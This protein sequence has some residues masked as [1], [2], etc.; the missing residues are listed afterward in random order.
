MTARTEPTVVPHLRVIATFGLPA[1]SLHEVP[2]DWST[3]LADGL[4]RELLAEV[5]RR[6]LAGL[7]LG[8]VEAGA[9]HVTQTQYRELG[10]VHLRWSTAALDLEVALLE[11]VDVLRA[12]G[13]EVIVLKGA[14][15]AHV[16]YR[17][18]SWRLFGDNDLL[19]RGADVARAVRLLRAIGYVRTVPELRHGFDARFGKGVTLHRPGGRE[20]D[21]HRTLLF[22]TFGLR[23]DTDELFRTAGSMD[24]AG[25]RLDVLGA[26]SRLLHLCYHAALGDPVP[27]LASLRDLAQAHA[28]EGHDEWGAVDLARRWGALPVVQRAFGLLR[29][30]LGVSIVGPLADEAR[31]CVLTAED[32]RAIGSY[33]GPDR[34]HT[35]KVLASLP[36]LDGPVERLAF[37]R[38]AA[39]PRAAVGRALGAGRWTRLKRGAASVRRFPRAVVDLRPRRP[40]SPSAHRDS[41]RGGPVK[42]K[43]LWLTKGLGLGGAERLLTLTAARLD[44]SRFEVDVAYVLPW[45]DAFVPELEAAGVRT[46]CLGASRTADPGWALGLRRL[47][48]D[49][50]YDIVH[51]HSPVPAIVARLLVDRSTKLVHTEHNLWDRYRWPTFAANAVTYARN[52][53][54][55]AVSDGVADSVVRPWWA[56]VGGTPEVET[57]LHGV[58]PD[59]VPRGAKARGAA[60]DALGLVADTP[61]LG[62]VANLT[63]KKD[64]VSLLEALVEVRTAHPAVVLLLI[65]AGPS[66]AD[67]QAKVAALDLGGSVRFLGSRSDVLDLLPALDVFVLSSRYE[68]LPISL[69]E[70][71]AAEVACVVT[72]VGGIPEVISDGVDGRL[73]PP[74]DPAALSGA[75]T[76]VLSDAGKREALAQAGRQRV[77]A[78]F[79]IDRAVARTEQLYAQ[80]LHR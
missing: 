33:V 46:I 30:D 61:V 39:L 4:W 72:R 68:G 65:G 66:E 70:A 32:R 18:P 80:L 76:D 60:R 44:R 48:H 9:L 17:D 5:D 42:T 22:G 38:S 16:L 28:V 64:H 71:M 74:A 43:V 24:L 58:A 56:R 40:R 67:L 37:L 77:L 14:A 3:P 7:L 53:A 73:V 57:L 23:V 49:E 11:A 47:L 59:A 75:L 10:E 15:H 41:S 27:K 34:G 51:T 25:T 45:K 36:Y 26:E 20:L 63:P 6:R 8:A 69:L 19:L 35:A 78:A 55:L 54:V 21:L 79:S 2:V 31:S 62:C 29:S 52:D 13:L 50:R 1:G 12:A